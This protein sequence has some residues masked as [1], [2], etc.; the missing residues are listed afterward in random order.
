MLPEAC[1]D[2]HDTVLGPGDCLV[3]YSDGVT[4]AL[5]DDDGEFG[6][7]RLEAM[8]ADGTSTSAAAMCNRLIAT[9]R[10]HRGSRQA[11]DDVTVL[12]IRRVPA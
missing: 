11:Q 9:V 3:C 8:I 10:D 1:Y 12:V 2:T 4:E 6:E 7:N 5:D